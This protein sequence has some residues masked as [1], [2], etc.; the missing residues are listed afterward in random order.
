M[1]NARKF[2]VLANHH[3]F[4]LMDAD[5][6]PPIPEEVT[7]QDMLQRLRTAP[8]IAV[9]HTESASQVPVEIAFVS[10]PTEAEGMWEHRAEFSLSLP[11][12]TAVLC[13]CTDF[14]PQCP[15]FSVAPSNYDG[16]A[17]FSG[18]RVSNEHYLIVLWPSAAQPI[19]PADLAPAARV[20]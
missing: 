13:G 12:G 18:S 20:R 5:I 2:N 9:F 15:Q 1:K 6:A 14:V 19:I 11:S 16:R 4:Y 3:Q 8:H 17:Y 10:K 7:E